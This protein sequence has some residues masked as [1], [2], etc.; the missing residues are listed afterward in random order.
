MNITNYILVVLIMKVRILMDNF[1]YEKI[2]KE[3]R[4]NLR[5]NTNM[6][7]EVLARLF[8]LCEL[9]IEKGILTDAEIEEAL[10]DE[11]LKNMMNEVKDCVLL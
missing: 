4:E 2:K 6:T 7:I 9:L 5:E 11:N 3:V 10:S 8:L 1:L